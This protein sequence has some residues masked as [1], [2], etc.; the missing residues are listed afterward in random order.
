MIDLEVS[1]RE[2]QRLLDFAGGD[3]DKARY[4]YFHN[5]APSP[6][7]RIP[8]KPAARS[9]PKALRTA[10]SATNVATVANLLSAMD[11]TGAEIELYAP[12]AQVPARVGPVDMNKSFESYLTRMGLKQCRRRRRPP[13]PPAYDDIDLGNAGTL[14]KDGGTRHDARKAKA[15]NHSVVPPDTSAQKD[16]DGSG[17]RKAGGVSQSESSQS[18]ISEK[19]SQLSALAKVPTQ[20][21]DGDK[22]V[23]RRLAAQDR[24]SRHGRISTTLDESVDLDT[25][26]TTA[27][28]NT[29]APAFFLRKPTQEPPRS[30]ENLPEYIPI[31]INDSSSTP[32]HDS[33]KRSLDTLPNLSTSDTNSYHLTER[34][35]NTSLPYDE[36]LKTFNTLGAAK[37]ELK[38]LAERHSRA[39]WV[40]NDEGKMVSRRP[41]YAAAEDGMGFSIKPK[42]GAIQVRV[43]I[44][45]TEGAGQSMGDKKSE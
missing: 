21:V 45:K 19:V 40:R 22:N 20:K 5:I 11:L 29:S 28:F 7:K 32:I 14:Q 33:K 23:F 43:W 42:G 4:N 13:R 25:H 17:L 16:Q 41:L 26:G 10:V 18:D 9:A 6:H 1:A 37:Q 3:A 39:K 35:Y 2:A 8:K 27:G 15:T 38:I 34:R 24:E 31:Y 30:I 44:A 12:A 36:V